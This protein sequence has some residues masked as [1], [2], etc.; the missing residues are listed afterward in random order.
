VTTSH[1]TYWNFF[2]IN[3]FQQFI[4]VPV[5][6][7]FLGLTVLQTFKAV[8]IT[9]GV[10]SIALPLTLVILISM[11]KDAYE[12]WRRHQSDAVE[13]NRKT[14]RLN[15]KTNQVETVKWQDIKVGDVLVVYD[16]EQVPADM[17][18]LCTSRRKGLCYVETSNLDG[19]TN[20][21][22]KYAPQKAFEIA[23]GKEAEAEDV[24]KVWGQM[25]GDVLVEQ[26][27][28]SL[29]T[30]TGS[31]SLQDGTRIPLEPKSI[32]LRGC[33]IA[34][35]E[36]VVGSAVYTGPDTKI[37]KSNKT[38]KRKKTS[39]VQRKMLTILAGILALML[40][41]CLLGGLMNAIYQQSDDGRIARYLN[42]HR[43]DESSDSFFKT[44]ILRFLTFVLI[45]GNFIPISLVVTLVVVRLGQAVFIMYDKSM[46]YNGIPAAARVSDINE[47]LG[48]VTHVF[49][50]KTGTLTANSM[51]FRKFCI[52]GTH[53]GQDAPK[54][55]SKM[56]SASTDFPTVPHQ[57]GPL[58]RPTEYTTTPSQASN[59][60]VVPTNKEA[61]SSSIMIAP[62]LIRTHLVDFWDD[63]LSADTL[64]DN[65]NKDQLFSIFFNWATNHT[66]GIRAK[67]S[68]KSVND[69][70][71]MRATSTSSSGSIDPASRTIQGSP[72]E[73]ALIYAAQH[74]GFVLIFKDATKMKIR[75]PGFDEEVEVN[76]LANLEFTT[77][78]RRS[79]VMVQFFDPFKNRD[80]TM[81]YTKG[82]DC[83]IMNRLKPGD[84]EGETALKI[85]EWNTKYAEEGLR[86]MMFAEKEL[87][88]EATKKWL[89]DYD[90]ALNEIDNRE[91]SV[92]LLTEFMETDMKLQGTVGIEDRL[93]DDV[94]NTVDMMHQAG[95][96][97]SMITGDK[98]ETA[99]NIAA[100]THIF[101]KDLQPK[102]RVVF[103]YSR[104]GISQDEKT[105]HSI[106]VIEA[107]A[108]LEL[109]QLASVPLAPV[110]TEAQVP[111]IP[112]ASSTS[113]L[114]SCRRLASKYGSKQKLNVDSLG[115]DI[116]NALLKR[117]SMA[118]TGQKASMV[119]EQLDEC[120]K[121]I[122]D[123]S[124][125]DKQIHA[126]VIDG[127]C[128][129][130]MLRYSDKFTRLVNNVT[131]LV[132]CR[133]S[134]HQ[135][136]EVVALVKKSGHITLAIGDGANDCDMLIKASVGVGI[137]GTEGVQAFNACDYGLNQFR[138]LQQL[139]FVHGRYAYRRTSY[140]ILY[141]FYKN[142]VV[143]IP[144]FLLGIYSAFSGQRLYP[145]PMYQM[146]NVY[147]GIPIMLWGVFDQDV[148]RHTC[149]DFPRLYK[150]GPSNLYL[151]T[152]TLGAT[153]IIGLFHS[154][155]IFFVPFFGI[156][157]P[158]N[159]RAD[160]LCADRSY[161]SVIVMLLEVIIV[162][163]T[164]I[165]DSYSLNWVLLLAFIFSFAAYLLPQV[166]L[167][168]AML[169]WESY[170]SIDVLSDAPIL[171]LTIIF[172]TLAI[173]L[174]GIFNFKATQCLYFPTPVQKV[175]HEAAKKGK[176][177]AAKDESR[178]ARHYDPACASTSS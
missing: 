138:F 176:L 110:I 154:V 86:T 140:V 169:Y 46:E 114:D 26:P 156:S 83:V 113:S 97:V 10:P 66:A 18:L 107:C 118:S 17:I 78:R 111:S 49:C 172:S 75:V 55:L 139:L 150:L 62:S 57:S 129:E 155:A 85:N 109:S 12:D 101:S 33:K 14:Q 98:S 59:A 94:A 76:M 167:S 126:L 120:L 30:F 141:M 11:L 151:N 8:S 106:Q 117:V 35:T 31:I 52:N 161:L 131:S 124:N 20:H 40:I 51:H 90:A 146:Y 47:E 170:G 71:R 61:T 153:I 29:Y 44:F 65:P 43:D 149:L 82:A 152:R 4:H 48:Q 165:F 13:N 128:L 80:V 102:H 178:A 77:A 159:S 32:V 158:G 70:T 133:V 168:I 87:E 145:D 23:A 1:Y 147:T 9:N 79:S 112:I 144:Q 53:Y 91:A 16:E 15:I 89:E 119:I 164:L 21:K 88:A 5:N 174:G 42:I 37:Q 84:A 2:V 27:N 96:K 123:V 175:M 157:F 38:K 122:D 34:N 143:V 54:E 162:N 22:I 136:G 137:R 108:D 63:N 99:I 73:A 50:D 148:P 67:T 127:A 116:E 173:A 166:V 92:N 163:M 45:F 134:P 95:M 60:P 105:D 74:F 36:W 56:I 64:M 28:S 104:L 103:D 160:G 177:V 121:R 130:E 19:E 3:L 93:Q 58:L 39:N 72:E 135:K 69:T 125:P 81:L 24:A 115:V 6:N 132:F 25:R 68:H 142:I 41:F 100:S 7:Y 171:S